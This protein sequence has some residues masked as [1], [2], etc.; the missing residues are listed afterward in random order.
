MP[1]LPEVESVRR[2]LL[3]SGL[4]G[5]TITRAEIGWAKTVKYPTAEELAAS[6]VGLTIEDV[7]RRAKYLFFPL[8]GP[9]TGSGQTTTT[10]VGHLGMTGNLVV[11]P[12]E[13]PPHPMTRHVFVLDDGRELRFVDGRKFGKLWLAADLGTILPPLGPEPLEEQF[14]T[15]WL[16]DS[17]A[18]RSAP[19]KALL[20]EQS[21]A[22][23]VGNIY[24]D[25]ALFLSGIRPDRPASQLSA[26]EVVRLRQG[27]IDCINAG[28]AVYDRARDLR[29]PEPP[30]PMGTW[31]HPRDAATPCPNCG[32]LMSSTR[33]R[34]R[35]TW[36][37]SNCQV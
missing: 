12:E 27:I 5:R 29:W 11:Q 24:A 10:L 17:F 7:G 22:A 37:C 28:F 21:I 18:K 8:A 33:I 4:V 36:Y 13:Q 31:S 23:G 35:G 2:S 25:E 3:R 26:D 19:V 30:E 16:A 1:E 14:T 9:S 15:E 34:A 20:L 6:V 32:G